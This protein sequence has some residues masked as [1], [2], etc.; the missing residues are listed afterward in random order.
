MVE[1]SAEALAQLAEAEAAIEAELEMEGP[2]VPEAAVG[3]GGETVGAAGAGTAKYLLADH[4]FTSGYRRFWANAGGGWR[5]RTTTTSDEYGIIQ[6]A[7]AS[8]RVDV[9]WNASNQ[10]YQ[11]RCW[12]IF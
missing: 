2:P 8:N 4:S 10:I 9:W 12:K 5:W 11:V 1:I 6:V 7:Y 3:F